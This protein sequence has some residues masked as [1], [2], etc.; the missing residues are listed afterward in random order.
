MYIK[1]KCV[2]EFLNDIASTNVATI[3]LCELIFFS[4]ALIEVFNNETNLSSRIFICYFIGFS[5]LM[6]G[7]AANGAHKV[8]IICTKKLVYTYQPLFQ[9]FQKLGDFIFEN[10]RVSYE[11]YDSRNF[12]TGLQLLMEIRSNPVG[13]KAHT[14]VITY[15]LLIT[16]RAYCCILFY[17]S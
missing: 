5:I 12:A 10:N 8:D 4:R 9:Q 2:M 13:L 3:L 1:L 14:F 15:G 11:F 6:Y 16:V 7:I 17:A